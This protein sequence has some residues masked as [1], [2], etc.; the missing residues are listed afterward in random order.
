MDAL[1]HAKLYATLHHVERKGQLYG[2]LPYTHHL[3]DVEGVLREFCETREFMLVAAWLHDIIEDTEVKAKDIEENFDDDVL[4]VVLA[5]TDD[6]GLV[7]RAA[8]KALAYPRIRAAGPDAIR[9][10]LA[11]RIANTRKGGGMLKKYR[12]EYP[13]FRLNLFVD[14]DGNQPMWETLDAIMLWEGK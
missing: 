5:V 11:D 1:T 8:K 9:M 2:V 6:A 14:G 4:R 10:K 13:Q 12:K 7:D 3:S